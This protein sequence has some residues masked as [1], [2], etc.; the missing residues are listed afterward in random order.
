MKLKL[1]SNKQDPH[2]N[3]KLY[4]SIYYIGLAF[5]VVCG[6]F[7]GLPNNVEWEYILAQAAQLCVLIDCCFLVDAFCK[8]NSFKGSNHVIKRRHV[9]LLFV[10]FGLYG[11]TQ[12]LLMT[13][14]KCA[15]LFCL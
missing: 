14:Y 9:V 4:T 12:I 1:I 11:L 13:T 10:S 5:N 3:S 2:T 8:I 7:Y 15:N 6:V